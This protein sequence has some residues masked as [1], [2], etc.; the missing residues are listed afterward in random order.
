MLFSQFPFASRVKDTIP[1][2]PFAPVEVFGIRFADHNLGADNDNPYGVHLPWEKTKNIKYNG[3]E[4]HLVWLPEIWL[5]EHFLDNT[6]YRFDKSRQSG[7]FRGK[8]GAEL[9]LPAAGVIDYETCNFWHPGKMGAYW[10]HGIPFTSANDIRC[11]TFAY[12]LVF[13]ND[14][15]RI[16]RIPANLGCSVRFG[17]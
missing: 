4:N 8:T 16:D 12:A 3:I 7:V 2:D 11:T 10:I 1:Y 13:D 14:K 15:A 9:V 6:E 17:V 5:V